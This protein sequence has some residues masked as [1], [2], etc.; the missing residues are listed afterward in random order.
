MVKNLPA[1]AG[2]PGDLGSIPGLGRS[3]E[4]GNGNSLQYSCLENPIDRKALWATVHGVS[5]SQIQ[6]STALSK[7][8]VRRSTLTIL[9]N[10]LLDLFFYKLLP[11]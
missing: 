10:I 9:I 1:N 3:P 11:L 6:L 5:K 8:K 7:I 4:V 2:G